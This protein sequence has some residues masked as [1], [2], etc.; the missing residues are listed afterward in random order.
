MSDKIIVCKHKP[1]DIT[2]L[3]VVPTKSSIPHFSQLLGFF[4]YYAPNISSAHAKDFDG[5]ALDEIY[6]DF[7][8]NTTIGGRLKF[9]QKIQSNSYELMG[10]KENCFCMKCERGLLKTYKNEKEVVCILRHIR[11]SLAHGYLYVKSKRMI[12]FY[13]YEDKKPSAKIVMNIETLK[14]LK[15]VIENKRNDT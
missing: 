14:Q 10:L 3:L 9:L 8:K 4:L 6:Q 13:D 2:P 5:K 12:C 11:N 1:Q 15:T 7:I